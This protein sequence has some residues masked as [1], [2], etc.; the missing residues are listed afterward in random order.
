MAD[1][2]LATG[3]LMT[4]QV[5]RHA[6]VIALI[7]ILVLAFVVRLSWMIFFTHTIESEGVEYAQIARNLLAGNGYVGMA[8]Q[9][10]QLTFPPLFPY[11]IASVAFLVHD[12]ELAGRLVSISMGTLLVL[13]VFFITKHLYGIKAG[14]ISALLAS[15]HPLLV[16]FS[17]AVYVET[18]YIVLLLSGAYC[19]LQAVRFRRAPAFVL[20][21]LFFG[22]A[23]T[24]LAPKRLSIHFLP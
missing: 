11:L 9:G 24:G 23:Y 12:V 21:G 2:R 16:G 15:V 19:C 13:P 8:T 7:L 5:G 1:R 10:S 4:K 3:K 17:A 14:F 6:W 18:T 20:I 22:M